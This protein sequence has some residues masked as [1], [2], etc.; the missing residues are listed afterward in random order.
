MI[1]RTTVF[2]IVLVAA[3]I[4]VAAYSPVVSNLPLSR[5][6]TATVSTSCTTFAGQATSS[7]ANGT[8]TPSSNSPVRVDF[9]RANIYSGQDGVRTVQFDLGYT[10]VGSGAIYVVK[11]CGSSLNSTITSGGGVVETVRGGVRCLCAEAS[12]AVEPGQSQTAVDPGCWSGYYYRVVHSGSFSIA[13]TLGWS[14]NTTLG[15]ESGNVTVAA[16]FAVS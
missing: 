13:L 3:V 14:G 5:S 1:A 7:V 2:A 16:N 4:G 11:G 10:N 12:S 6:S 9:V 8:F 15:S